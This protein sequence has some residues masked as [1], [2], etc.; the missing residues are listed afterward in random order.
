MYVLS[1]AMRHNLGV[2]LLTRLF[3]AQHENNDTAL[4]CICSQNEDQCGH[5]NVHRSDKPVICRHCVCMH[6]LLQAFTVNICKLKQY[7]KTWITYTQFSVKL[8]IDLVL[9]TISQ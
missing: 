2:L 1:C 7:S 6:T 8:I 3:E 4:L 9:C 5:A